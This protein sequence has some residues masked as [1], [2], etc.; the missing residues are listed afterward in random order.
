MAKGKKGFKLNQKNQKNLVGL[1][2]GLVGAASI[3]LAT[4]SSWTVPAVGATHQYAKI[5]DKVGDFINFMGLG[6]G[7]LVLVGIVGIGIAS[8]LLRK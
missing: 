1:G 4:H 5:H 2:A 3:T 8:L 7:A 6:N